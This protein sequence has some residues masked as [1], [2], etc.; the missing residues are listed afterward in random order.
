M[1][2]DPKDR[3]NAE[4]AARHQ[5]LVHGDKNLDVDGMLS[6]SSTVVSQVQSILHPLILQTRASECFHNLLERAA[7]R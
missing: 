5:F 2:V 1:Q 7:T 6:K 3:P 4:Q